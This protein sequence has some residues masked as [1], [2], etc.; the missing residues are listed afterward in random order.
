MA[1]IKKPKWDDRPVSKEFVQEHKDPEKLDVAWC[2]FA[3]SVLGRQKWAFL[4]LPA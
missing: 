3:V 4:G 2:V 1:F